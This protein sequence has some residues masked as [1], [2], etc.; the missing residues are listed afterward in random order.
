MLITF[1]KPFF[2]ALY[3]AIVQT[4]KNANLLAK[5][6]GGGRRLY[7]TQDAI[8]V[9]IAGSREQVIFLPAAL[10]EILV[11]FKTNDASNDPSSYTPF[12]II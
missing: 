3:T 5:V 9:I 8:D 7:S 11:L 4:R 1:C 12:R 2:R 10:P 6:V